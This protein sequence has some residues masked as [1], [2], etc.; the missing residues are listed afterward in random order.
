MSESC[1]RL[2]AVQYRS[3]AKKEVPAESGNARVISHNPGIRNWGR[4]VD[5]RGVWFLAKRNSRQ[6][7]RKRK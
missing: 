4:Y 6:A 1:L 2:D 5:E 7:P 3:E